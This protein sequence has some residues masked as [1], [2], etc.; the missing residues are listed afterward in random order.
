MHD[1]ETNA[2]VVSVHFRLLK[3]LEDFQ[4]RLKGHQHP[5]LGE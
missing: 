2:R 1:S 3:A 5:R 4:I